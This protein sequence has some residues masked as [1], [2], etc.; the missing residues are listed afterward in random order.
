MGK[1]TW[2]HDPVVR[3]LWISDGLYSNQIV[4]NLLFPMSFCR[5]CRKNPAL[6]MIGFCYQWLH[7]TSLY[8]NTEILSTDNGLCRLFWPSKTF[9]SPIKILLH[10]FVQ[11]DSVITFSPSSISN[12]VLFYS[13]FPLSFIFFSSFYIFFCIF[14]HR[15]SRLKP[16]WIS[17]HKGEEINTINFCKH[18]TLNFLLLNL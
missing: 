8:K 11:V 4:A 16:T 13:S 14:C 7:V 15:F 5:N 17:M 10:T 6:N 18:W 2:L 12:M 3:H 9:H 1:I